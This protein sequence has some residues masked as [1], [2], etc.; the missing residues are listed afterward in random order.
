[1]VERIGQ[2]KHCRNC[3][4]AIPYKDLYCNDGCETE[5]KTKM[6]KKKNQLMYFYI[7]MVI[8]M[9]FAVTLMFLG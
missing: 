4:K 3:E 7:V 1:M 5:W 9:I 2:H 8:I 6:S